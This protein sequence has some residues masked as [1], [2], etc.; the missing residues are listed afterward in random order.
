MNTN[1]IIIRRLD[2]VTFKFLA[3]RDALKSTKKFLF[4]IF[5]KCFKDKLKQDA[6]VPL[7]HGRFSPLSLLSVRSGGKMDS[8]F[9]PRWKTFKKA[10][11]LPQKRFEGIV[12]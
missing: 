9:C 2:L 7:P 4:P 5:S 8:I 12:L 1:K 3:F 6:L 10:K 11:K